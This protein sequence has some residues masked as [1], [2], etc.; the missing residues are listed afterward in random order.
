MTRV[1]TFA[2]FAVAFVATL[3]VIACG[4]GSGDTTNTTP[5]KATP[6]SLIMTAGK[7]E[8]VTISGGSSDIKTLQATASPVEICRT[9]GAVGGKIEI[10]AV[11]SGNCN[12]LATNNNQEV[13]IPVTVNT[14]APPVDNGGGN[15]GTGGNNGGEVKITTMVATPTVVKT[16]VN[17]EILVK[18]SQPGQEYPLDPMKPQASSDAKV[19]SATWLNGK[20]FKVNGVSTG[21][22][23]I[24]FYGKD[25][26]SG[27]IPVT[28]IAWM[29][30]TISP[31]G[32]PA[33]TIDGV[34][35]GYLDEVCDN[36]ILDGVSTPI[37]NP[38]T[39]IQKG[40]TSPGSRA[41]CYKPSMAAMSSYPF[42]VYG[43]TDWERQLT[44]PSDW[45]FNDQCA[46]VLWWEYSPGVTKAYF[47]WQLQPSATKLDGIV[48]GCGA[49]RSAWADYL[50]IGDGGN[51]H[52]IYGYDDLGSKINWPSFQQW[53]AT[54]PN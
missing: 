19:C 11:T 24:T 53:V 33:E 45:S 27:I 7:S 39:E 17:G 42:M 43:R 32:W 29:E 31:T 5:L 22:C 52:A 50:S 28:V 46:H 4:G 10:T 1:A 6:S 54:L 25:G 34:S 8:I 36:V 2:K 51:W 41:G 16:A 12:I 26:T 9:S 14:V 3:L 23:V 48:A 15:G 35:T 44:K 38:L 30:N 47:A 37:Q 20:S 21:N 13:K 18:V 49:S 40:V